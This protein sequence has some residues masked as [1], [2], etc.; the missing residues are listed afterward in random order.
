MLSEKFF[1]FILSVIECL[2]PR[3]SITVLEIF[4]QF[5]RRRMVSHCF[6]LHFLITCDL[7]ISHRFVD[8]LHFFS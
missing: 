2:A 4:S 8:L 1:Q 5:G 3:L 6:N 7:S